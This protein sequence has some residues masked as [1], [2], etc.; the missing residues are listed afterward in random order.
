MAQEIT[1]KDVLIDR[2][3]DLAAQTG[4]V[5]HIPGRI[6]LKVKLSGLL[7]ARD[8]DAADLMKYFNGILDARAN[9]AARSIVISYD[10]TVIAPDLWERLVNAKKDPRLRYSV[11][12]Q[13]ERLSRP[14][15]E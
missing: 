9:A 2:L 13:L 15:L 14:G 3:I 12:A 10:E 11:K 1:K 4:I 5:H 8:L 6:R 7:L